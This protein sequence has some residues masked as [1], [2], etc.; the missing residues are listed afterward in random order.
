MRFKVRFSARG[1]NYFS[2]E[3]RAQ[4]IK[5]YFPQPGVQMSLLIPISLSYY[6]P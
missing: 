5:S 4:D 3:S 6:V 2:A 1:N